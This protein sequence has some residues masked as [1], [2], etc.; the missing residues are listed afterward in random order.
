[1]RGEILLKRDA[2][3]GS[4]SGAFGLRLPSRSEQG[5]RSFGLR[6]ALAL[7]KLFQSNGRPAEAHAVLAP[8]SK[9]FRDAGDARDRGGAGA[10]GDYRGRRA[11]EA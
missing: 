8:R 9:A 11:W 5:A 10:V 2:S 1:M 7:A 6:A 3:N 4:G